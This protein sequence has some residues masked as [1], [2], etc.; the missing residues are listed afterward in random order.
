MGSAL[1][2]D[3]NVDEDDLYSQVPLS[4]LYNDG[5]LSTNVSSLPIFPGTSEDVNDPH[6]MNFKHLRD[7]KKAVAHAKKK[8]SSL[9]TPEFPFGLTTY[10]RETFLKLKSVHADIHGESKKKQIAGTGNE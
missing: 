2:L 5:F 3:H 1:S 6:N 7:V 8:S 4:M 9:N 10:Q